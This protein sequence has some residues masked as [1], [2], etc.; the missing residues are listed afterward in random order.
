[1]ARSVLL[2]FVGAI[3]GSVAVYLLADRVPGPVESSSSG[4]ITEPP[5]VTAVSL[6]DVREIEAQRPVGRN[7]P[8]SARVAAYA[9]AADAT[10]AIDLESMI[11]L[12][13]VAPRS[14]SRDLELTA[15]LARLTELDPY[16]AVAT[17]LT[18]SLETRY[19][20]QA[21]ESLARVDTDAAIVELSRVS[22]LGKQRR[23]AL[24]LLNVLGDD[25]SAIE[26]IAAALP[27]QSRASFELDALIARAEFDMV[28]AL[29]E[30]VNQDRFASQSY[31][32]PR[33]A[34]IV[35]RIDP[36]AALELARSIDNY[37]TR[38]TLQ[39]S[40]LNAWGAI[41]PEAVFGFLETAD[42]A[43]LA[44]SA[45]VFPVIAQSDPGRLL[46]MI[47]QFPP[48]VRTSASRAAMQTLADRDPVAA[49]AM[50]DAMPPGQDREMMLQTIAQS[51]GRQSP[52]LALS[53]V[54]SLSPPSENAMRSVLQG[55]A[56]VDVDRAID[57]MVAEVANQPDTRFGPGTNPLATLS[58]SMMMSVVSSNGTDVGRVADR[59][60]GLDNPQVS[61]MMSTVISVWV[62][63]DSDA[64]IN[65]AMA[66]IERFEPLV[67]TRLAQSVANEN[68]DRAVSTL[69]IIPPEQRAAWVEGLVSQ[70]AT[71]DV[72]RAIN[73]VEPYR[74]LPGYE[75]AYGTVLRQMA[76]TDPVRAARLL[77]GAPESNAL[78][79]AAMM[80]TREWA[81]RDPGSAAE[82]ALNLENAEDRH[83]ALTQVASMWAQRDAA[84]A[85]RWLFSLN[86]E[87]SREAVATS[88]LLS[89]AQAGRFNARLLEAFSSDRARQ[90]AATAVAVN[91]VRTS[92][93]EARRI[94]DSHVTDPTLREQA[95]DSMNRVVGVSIGVPVSD[96]N[97]IFTR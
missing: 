11:Q 57:L 22:S 31:A 50:L 63:R 4:A 20:I 5:L 37:T 27:E 49:L 33:V 8:V 86:S 65:W 94:L 28:G 69:N 80:I 35:A 82:W 25:A 91:L 51:Y 6:P 89:A 3:G 53:W 42:P 24:A 45:G 18:A 59:L 17:A 56:A 7:E 32:L 93:D 36:V 2:L 88:L 64:A 71:V 55:I 70:M 97:V 41:D 46:A 73:F 47:D 77:S 74:E 23:T 48:T 67:M 29:Q 21:F 12:A 79:T 16:R 58:F 72:D 81:A 92:P 66:N 62:S 15:L 19:L 60:L 84:A 38:M 83:N 85:E 14:R 96:G 54:K 34:E 68:L 75:S 13:A 87:P 9:Q 39:N 61:S 78:R 90:Q 44:M 30:L 26:Q 1:M 95:E 52:D 40:I 43:V 76:R 10:D